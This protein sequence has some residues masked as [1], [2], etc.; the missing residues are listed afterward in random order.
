MIRFF[1]L[2]LIASLGSPVL[3][4]AQTNISGTVRDGSTGEPLQG[5][6]VAIPASQQGTYTDSAGTYRLR[7]QASGEITLRFSFTGYEPLS[8]TV[9]VAG[10]SLEVDVVLRSDNFSTEDVVITATK[11]FEQEQS[12]VTMSISVVKPQ[13]IDLQATPN[14]E[15]VINQVPGVDNQGGQ[16]NIRGSSGYA[17]GVG[18]RVMVTLDG[19]PLLTGD[20]G[21]AT[22][23]LIPVDNV[24]QVEVMKGAASV[25]YGSAALGGVINVITADPGTVPKTRIRMRGGFYGNPRNPALDWDGD[26][27][28]W[29]SSAHIFHSRQAGDLSL[30]LQTDLIKDSGYRQGTDTER[31]RGLIMTKYQPKSIPGLS[32]GVNVSGRIDSS[33]AMLYWRSYYPDSAEVNGE[34]VVT[35]GALTPTQDAGGYRRQISSFL[36][37]DPIVKY[38]TPNGN[39]FWYRG[40][41][42]RN[43]NQNNTGQSNQNWIS[44]NDFLY[45][46]TLG[47]H[48]NWVTGATF[49]YAIANGDS[50][51]GGRRPGQSLGVY[52]QLD[53][54]FGRL[55]ASLG[56]RY[57]TAKIDTLPRESQPILRAGL[58]YELR[59]GSNLRASFGQAFR[60]PTVAERYANTAG[61]GILI[62]P[63]P[64]IA[65]E[66]G[67]SLE[68]GYRQGYRFGSSG[69]LQA[70]GYLD[71]ALFRMA[72]DNMV[73]FGISN[74]QPVSFSSVNV[75]EAQIDGIEITTLN[76]FQ[77]GKWFATLS[78]GLTLL[79]PQNLNSV[80][81]T[82][83]LNLEQYDYPRQFINAL[84]DLS[85]PNLVDQ[86]EVLK[87]R[88]RRLLRMSGSV[89]YGRFSL[90]SNVRYRS[91]IETVDQYLFVVVEDFA[92][93]RDRHPNGEWVVD[94]IGAVELTERSQLSLTVDNVTNTEYLVIPGFLAAQRRYTLQYLIRF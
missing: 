16:I 7:V 53:G 10:T 1:C 54:K 83:Q 60:V 14:I 85:N 56:L 94:L 36:A 25:L 49:T 47:D 28:A 51:Y 32:I 87:Y 63:N 73:E 50:I 77:R 35:G 24:A 64:T 62:E 2:L 39:L 20:A 66:R 31:F 46:T 42:L 33:S 11:G 4:Q 17:Y 78:G 55:N 37:V 59:K 72:Y 82:R 74:L 29:Y 69:R 71:V 91:F 9:T 5:A 58:N 8:R 45:Q 27:N 26:A 61:G 6:T 34:L 75:A 65:S 12:D 81:S 76:Q 79:D 88:P 3:S 68:F 44:Y 41:Y 57:E 21:T 23:D 30:T 52:T 40:R 86:P 92:D 18:S 90:T 93:F 15:R 48:I 22:L 70:K 38:L 89:G 13:S 19:L 43:S 67:Y 84:V 80:D